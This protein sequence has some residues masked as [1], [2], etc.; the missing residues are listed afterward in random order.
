MIYLQTSKIYTG[1]YIN[2]AKQSPDIELR[3]LMDDDDDG[4]ERTLTSSAVDINMIK[5]RSS[6]ISTT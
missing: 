5:E 6:R 3:G 4:V 1:K 2:G